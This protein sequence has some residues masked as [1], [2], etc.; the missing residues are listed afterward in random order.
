MGLTQRH[1]SNDTSWMSH[2]WTSS[3]A[4]SRLQWCLIPPIFGPCV[5]DPQVGTPTSACCRCLQRLESVRY[6][7]WPPDR[8]HQSSGDIVGCVAHASARGEPNGVLEDT[9]IVG[10]TRQM[11]EHRC[12]SGS[13]PLKRRSRPAR[14]ERGWQGGHRPPPPEPNS[15]VHLHGRRTPRR[16]LAPDDR[17]SNV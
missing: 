1:F 8:H 14:R 13:A 4:A 2:S 17:S 6:R 15:T 11:I 7:P 9:Y 12:Q 10:E 16:P 5:N 3:R